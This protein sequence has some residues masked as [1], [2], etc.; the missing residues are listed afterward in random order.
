[1]HLFPT[2]LVYFA[3]APAALVLLSDASSQPV[4]GLW[5]LLGMASA[6]SAVTIEFLADRQLRTYRASKDYER[7]GTLRRGLW[8]SRHPNYFGEAL[9]WLS[10]VPFAVAAGMLRRHPALVLGGPI[11]M[12]LFFRYSCR[13]MDVRS[14][15]RR[16]GYQRVIDEVSAM[17]PWWPKSRRYDRQS[18]SAHQAGS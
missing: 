16:P 12:A 18:S 7:G 6:L 14:L 5:D 17:I 11:M 15:Q 10:M 1:M 3:F 9:F 8:K 4:F 13:L 2:A